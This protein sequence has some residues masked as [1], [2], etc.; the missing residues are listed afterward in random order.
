MSTSATPLRDFISKEAAG[1]IALVLAAAV[2]MLWVNMGG[3]DVYRELLASRIAIG[4]WSLAIDKPL[5]LW[6]N[7]GLMALF[8]FLIGLEVKRELVTGQLATWR[9]AAL[10]VYA[11][12]G[13]M[14]VPALIF[15]AINWSVPANLN[16]WAIPA[17]T[18]IAFALGLLALLG[19]RVPIA[20]KAL[21]LAVAIIDDI[22]A[23]VII[24]LFYTADL[25]LAALGLALLP[26]AGLLLLNRFGVA[27]VLPY[28]LLGL[29][30]WV[31]VLKSGV[32]ATLAGVAAAM[33]IPIAASG[34]RP[35]ARLEHG[36][37]PWIVFAVLPI[38]AFANAGVSFANVGGEALF[39]PLSLGIAA[40]LVVGKQVGIFGACLIAAKAK[41]ASVPDG[42]TLR[43][44][45]GLSCL[46]GIG[47]TMSL[48]IGGLA[49]VETGQIEAVKI[50]VLS[51]SLVSAIIGM[52][53]LASARPLTTSRTAEAQT[54]V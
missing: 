37:H 27:R 13:G 24:A 5:L 21:L 23:I 33:F 18:D 17:A 45:Y 19:T 6:I 46:A 11:A 47:F 32:H 30:L 54:H 7:D 31:F 48:F 1:G 51:G 52:A 14:V 15:V 22:G 38:F 3:A 50:G 16:G 20:L 36:L 34:Q 9:Q 8:F 40:G 44:L 2:A 35:L 39:A 12:I 42:V 10:P 25:N 28:I 4:G 49:F 53:V 29:V 41:L 43:Q 26:L